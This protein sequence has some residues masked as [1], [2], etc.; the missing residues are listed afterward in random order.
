M[1]AAARDITQTRREMEE[2]VRGLNADLEAGACRSGRRSS[3]PANKELKAFPYSVSHDLRA[4][5]RTSS[6]W[7]SDILRRHFDE[8]LDDEG[9]RLIS[10]IRS[11]TERIG[12]A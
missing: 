7:I 2:E 8:K 5:L 10:I 12:P 4:P 3:R 11:N 6:G 9:R 1:Y